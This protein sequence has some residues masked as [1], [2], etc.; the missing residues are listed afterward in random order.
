LYILKYFDDELD[1]EIYESFKIEY[2][3]FKSDN[4]K[5][6]REYMLFEVEFTPNSNTYF[7]LCDKQKDLGSYVNILTRQGISKA[8]IINKYD[9]YEDELPLPLNKIVKLS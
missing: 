8:K 2:I 6:D 5:I 4:K 3:L 7:Y 9:L 1:D